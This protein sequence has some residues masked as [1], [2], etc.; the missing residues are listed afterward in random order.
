MP[1]FAVSASG[2][3]VQTA[4]GPNQLLNYDKPMTKLDTTNIVSFQTI[5][6]ILNHEPPQ[7]PSGSPYYTDTIVYQFKHGYNY[8]PAIW[9]SWNFPAAN[10]DPSTPAVGTSNTISY[11]NGNDS[12]GLVAYEATQGTIDL[13]TQASKLAIQQYNSS[14]SGLFNATDAILYATVDATYVYVHIMKRTLATVGSAIVPLYLIGY[15]MNLR[16][17]VFCEP[18]TTST[19]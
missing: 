7:A 18:A 8:V 1:P 3:S 4:T 16:V 11:P 17:D 2:A 9:L 6:L 19:Y 15:I 12:G 14:T 10:P 13:T 5:Q